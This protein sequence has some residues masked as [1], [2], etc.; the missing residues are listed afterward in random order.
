MSTEII[1]AIIGAVAVVAAAIIAKP[2]DNKI[3]APKTKDKKQSK[4]FHHQI[5]DIEGDDNKAY[6]SKN[7]GGGSQSANIKGNRNSINQKIN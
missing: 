3:K 7:G 5:A 1:V 6:Q 4:G 2:K